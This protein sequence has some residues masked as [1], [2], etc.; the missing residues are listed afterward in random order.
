MSGCPVHMTRLAKPAATPLITDNSD[1][2]SAHHGDDELLD[3]TG[4]L[5][6]QGIALVIFAVSLVMYW[7]L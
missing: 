4:L 6:C 5:I 3:D 7:L 2:S 1:A